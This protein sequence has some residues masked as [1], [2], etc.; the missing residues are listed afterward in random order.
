MTWWLG[1][2]TKTGYITDETNPLNLFR[3]GMDCFTSHPW[4]GDFEVG[5]PFRITG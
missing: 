2:F 3:G 4:Q 5:D 1:K